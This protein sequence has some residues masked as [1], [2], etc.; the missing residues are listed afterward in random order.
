MDGRQLERNP[1]AGFMG[2][3]VGR[4][5]GD[6]RVVES[7]GFKDTT[8]LDFGGNPHSESLRIVERYRRTDFGHVRREIT[9]TDPEAF[10]KPITVMSDLVLNPDTELLEV[11]VRR[12]AAR[13]LLAGGKNRGGAEGAGCMTSGGDTLRLQVLVVGALEVHERA[14]GAQ[15]EDASRQSTHE[16]AIV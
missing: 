2:Y 1:S 4:W 6:E 7:N 15:L 3:S 14:A 10:K 9:L 12:N 16:L 11:R 13:A 8:W 5:E